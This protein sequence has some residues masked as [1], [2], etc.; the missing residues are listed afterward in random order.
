[1]TETE[2]MEM[3]V[4]IARDVISRI[5][6]KQISP[7]RTTYIRLNSWLDVPEDSVGTDSAQPIIDQFYKH[8]DVCMLGAMFLSHINLNNGVTIEDVPIAARPQIVEFLREYWTERELFEIE[9]WYQGW[10][11]NDSRM[12]TFYLKYFWYQYCNE[13]EV[14]KMLME[15][16]VANGGNFVPEQLA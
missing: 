10:T 5:D 1:M 2:K 11:N 14:M 6:A 7:N 4:K 15:N 16:I 3:R 9:S 13:T 8:C 12:I